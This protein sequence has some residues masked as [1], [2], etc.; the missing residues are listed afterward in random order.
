MYLA[1]AT[2]LLAAGLQ[3]GDRVGIWSP[4]G[5]EWA[6]TQFATARAGLILVTINPAYRVTEV[7]YALNKVQ[8]AALV[9]APSFKTSDYLGMLRELA[10]ELKEA[11]PG[12]LQSKRL[13]SLRSVILLGDSWHPGTFRFSEIMA[14][15]GA[16]EE[17]GFSRR[18]G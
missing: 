15:G 5:A 17:E 8:C 2:G 18:V 9:T 11:Q 6:L 7:E 10:P 4:N 14:R 13:P 12:Q 1:A 16:A 3:P